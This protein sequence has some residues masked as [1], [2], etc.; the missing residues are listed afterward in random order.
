MAVEC[1]LSGD[2]ITNVDVGF[3]SAV[4]RQLRST[5]EPL[6]AISGRLSLEKVALPKTGSK[7]LLTSPVV[8]AR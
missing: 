5:G 4:N 6:S 2:S 1:P 8:R 3:G 7:V